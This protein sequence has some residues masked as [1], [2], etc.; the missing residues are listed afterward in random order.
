M[1]VFGRLFSC[2]TQLCQVAA[3]MSATATLAFW[4]W[5]L[6]VKKT[7]LRLPM[8][9]VFFV[10]TGVVVLCKTLGAGIS[11]AI[12]ISPIIVKRYIGMRLPLLVL[13][14]I[15]PAY[16]LARTSG[17]L[18]SQTILSANILADT[19]RASSL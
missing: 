10:L 6:R 11:L 18:S 19:D 1:E 3:W 17:V 7:L 4:L 15:P 5:R 14:I 2:N 12:A 9:L 13:A 8:W 16:M